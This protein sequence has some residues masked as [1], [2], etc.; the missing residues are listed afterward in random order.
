[1]NKTLLF[2]IYRTLIPRLKITEDMLNMLEK[3]S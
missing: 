2:D 1:M 3:L